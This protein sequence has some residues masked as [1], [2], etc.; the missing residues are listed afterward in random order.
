MA[1]CLITIVNDILG[2]RFTVLVELP[3]GSGWAVPSGYAAPGET[4]TGD[5]LLVLSGETGL[6]APAGAATLPVH[7]DLGRFR[8]GIPAVRTENG[9]RT[10]RWFRA[11]SYDLLCEE[12]ERAYGP[13]RGRLFTAHA[14]MLADFLAP[15]VEG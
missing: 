15:E 10:A 12:L 6:A 4:G 3:G 8:R 13:V 7:A 2:T 5:A 1:D 11:D 9:T 14:G